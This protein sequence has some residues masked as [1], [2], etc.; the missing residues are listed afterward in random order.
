MVHAD[1]DQRW[2][3]GGTHSSSIL[4][5][6][7]S[8]WGYG[9]EMSRSGCALAEGAIAT[10]Q[11]PCGVNV[12]ASELLTL[13][14]NVRAG[15]VSRSLLISVN[16]DGSAI[17]YA[18][19]DG[20]PTPLAPGNAAVVATRDEARLTSS[21]RI[22]DASRLIVVQACVDHLHDT[23]LAEHLDQR[24]RS[25]RLAPL[26]LDGRTRALLQGL[27][28]PTLGG[29]VGRLRAESCALALVAAALETERSPDEAVAPVVR[30]RDRAR[31]MQI[32]DQLL[33]NL[34][35]D[36]RLCDLAREAGMSASTFKLKFAAV[37]GQ[38][39]FQFLREQRLDR[40]REGLRC[41][42]W[43]VSQAAY[44][45]GYRH[46]TNFATA[47]RRRFGVSPKEAHRH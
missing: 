38:P 12:C 1:I 3:G 39:V 31:I 21:Y 18:L 37:V 9:C 16:L 32:R 19:N 33:A 35:T 25:P 45:V 34:D 41:D 20:A 15:F 4:G 46:P 36:H 22:G 43:T 44:Y 40:A 7:A 10:H 29:L 47:F 5:D 8:A 17:N 11:L 13:Q 6:I 24:L 27:F 14:D 23:D 28:S 26:A 42:G 30:P 2:R